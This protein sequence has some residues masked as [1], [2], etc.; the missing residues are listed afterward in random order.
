MSVLY[1]AIELQD[2][3]ITGFCDPQIRR[4]RLPVDV[5]VGM[6]QDAKVG[7]DTAIRICHDVG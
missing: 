3:R 7:L 6:F 5:K 4:E 2:S 1:G